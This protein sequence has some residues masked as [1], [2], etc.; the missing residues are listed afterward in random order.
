MRCSIRLG[1]A[2][3]LAVAAL[4]CTTRTEVVTSWAAPGANKATVK[5]VLVL[6]ISK[7]NGIRRTYEDEF[8]LKLGE[9][10]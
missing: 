10:G 3:I 8:A 7:D 1:T 6:G 5:K 9:M 4:A 2:A